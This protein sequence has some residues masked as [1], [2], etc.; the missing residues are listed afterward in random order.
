MR[1]SDWSSDVCSSDLA[2]PSASDGTNIIAYTSDFPVISTPSGQKISGRLRAA[3][4]IGR[5]CPP[6]YGPRDAYSLK[7]PGEQA[8]AQRSNVGSAVRDRLGRG[9]QYAQGGQWRVREGGGCC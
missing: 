7:S 1:I 6:G 4:P 2:A 3:H 9:Y 5:H 8:S